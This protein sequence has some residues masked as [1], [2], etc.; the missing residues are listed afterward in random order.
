MTKKTDY[1]KGWFDCYK[2][3]KAVVVEASRTMLEIRRVRAASGAN[4]ENVSVAPKK[5]RGRPPVEFQDALG[6]V[7]RTRKL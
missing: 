5:G 7:V 6:D 1:E 4:N 2:E 3:M